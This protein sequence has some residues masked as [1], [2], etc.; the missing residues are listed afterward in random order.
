LRRVN[1][2]SSRGKRSYNDST[3]IFGTRMAILAAWIISSLAF[4][5][6]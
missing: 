5:T 2:T 4:P 6:E 3:T 1:F